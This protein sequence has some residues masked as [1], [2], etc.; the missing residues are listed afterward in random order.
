M[1]SPYDCDL[2]V[3]GTGPAGQRAAI[4]A[5]KLG[6]RVAIVDRRQSVGGVCVNTGTI[7]SKTLREAILYLSGYRLKSVYGQDYRVKES[8]GMADLTVRINYVVR[9]EIQIIHAQMTRNGVRVLTGEARFEEPHTILVQDYERGTIR[10]TSEKFVLAPGTEP[11][12]PENVHLTGEAILDSDGVLAMQNIPRT[13]TV[14]G[15]GI[16]GLEY[17]SMF[18]TLGTKVT[19]VDG[20][21]RILEFVDTEIVDALTYHL[22]SHGVTFRLGEEV[23]YVEMIEGKPVAFLASGKRIANDTLLFSTGRQGRTEQLNLPAAGLTADDRGRLKVN[24]HYQTSVP[25][26]Y[27][28]GD[29]IGFPALASTAMEQG[30]LAALHACG[31]PGKSMPGLY[32]YAIYSVPEISM[33]GRTEHELTAACVPFESGVAHYR[34]ISRG[35]ILGDQTGLLKLLF[36]TETHELLGVHGIG[37]GASELIHVGQAVMAHHGKVEYFRDTVFNYPT[38]AECYKVAALNGLNKLI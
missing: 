5:A 3:V 31:Q 26:I 34:E 7:P 6:R 12:R 10:V 11:A 18:A 28:A 24:E 21:Q 27:A 19:L 15:G 4:A 37:E 1:S 29:V 17:A 20:R 36:H 38:L 14:L 25:H 32:P 33:V 16:I 23:V 2:L 35:Q 13:M 9:N 8:I 22:R 30:R